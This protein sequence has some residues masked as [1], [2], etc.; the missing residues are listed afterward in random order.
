MEERYWEL[1][2]KCERAY[3][4]WCS[5]A[6]RSNYLAYEKAQDSFKGFCVDVLEKLMEEN[7]EVLKNLKYNP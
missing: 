2:E 1:R 4:K 6:T 7:A 5:Q 3:D